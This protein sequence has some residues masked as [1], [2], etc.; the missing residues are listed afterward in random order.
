MPIGRGD[1]DFNL[2]IGAPVDS[3]RCVAGPTVPTP[4][5]A[6][7]RDAWRLVSNLNLNY[8]SIGGGDADEGGAAAAMLRQMLE[9]HVDE[10]SGSDRR[11]LE[12]I[13]SVSTSPAVRQRHYRGHVEIA[14]GLEV[15]IRLDESAFQGTG[16]YLLG[17]V[18]ERFFARYASINSFTETVLET[19]QRNEVERW[20]IQLG[21]RQ[22]L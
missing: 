5:R 8:L 11:Q 12:G 10:N 14:H 6:H 3:I 16:V 9:L 18:L 1:T 2:D 4:G 7:F 20:P 19:L 17:A 22:I 15:R 21:Q 13:M